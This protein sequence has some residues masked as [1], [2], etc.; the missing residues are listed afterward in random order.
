M[1]NRPKITLMS[2]G[3]TIASVDQ[4]GVGAKPTLDV[5]DIARKI[6]G[7]A[8]IADVAS[9]PLAVVPSPHMNFRDLHDLARAADAAIAD[10]ST[11]VVVTQGT[12]TI[13]EIAYG[14][15]LMCAHEAPIVVTGAMRN[16]SMPGADGPAKSSRGDQNG[17]FKRSTRAWHAGRDER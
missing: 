12:D 5:A 9:V 17:R 11:G 13:E 1:T 10:G 15:D 2:C 3:G 8:E 16:A 4:P 7:V 14:L 6:P